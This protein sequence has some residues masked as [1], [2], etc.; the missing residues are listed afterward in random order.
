M[1]LPNLCERNERV[2]LEIT[3]EDIDVS[4]VREFVTQPDC[5][6]QVIFSGQTRDHSSV[7]EN[8]T[9]LEYSA[10]E[11]YVLPVFRKI[12]ETVMDKGQVRRIA[13]VHKLGRVDLKD[14]SVVVAVCSPHRSESFEAAQYVIDALKAEAPIWKKEFSQTDSSWGELCTH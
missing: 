6:A 7:L 3:Y 2:W 8:V 13:V 4:E 1:D 14:T 5:G 9:H 10:Y 11:A 12:V